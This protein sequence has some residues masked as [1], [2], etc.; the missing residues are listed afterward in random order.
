M[1][2]RLVYSTITR[3]VVIILYGTFTVVAVYTHVHYYIMVFTRLLS[4]RESMISN[5]R[6]VCGIMHAL[7]HR[8]VVLYEGAT[9]LFLP[10]VLILYVYEIDTNR[11]E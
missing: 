5:C 7:K 3:F 8:Y 9:I 1:V 2:A 10:Y 4:I 11:T 6:F